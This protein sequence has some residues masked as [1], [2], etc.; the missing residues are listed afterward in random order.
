MSV[1]DIATLHQSYVRLS[2]RFKAM[3]TFHQYLQ[4]VH[5]AFLGD[6]PKVAA[7]FQALYE[8][9]KSV[10]GLLSAGEPERLRKAIAAISD[11]LTRVS[12]ELARLDQ[13][14]STS[15]L[16]RFFE[17]VKTQ[18]EKI[19]YN[20][21]KFHLYSDES[22]LE[23]HDKLDFLF[24]RLAERWD[25]VSNH[26]EMR[27]RGELVRLL[28][29]FVALRPT[30]RPLQPEEV[31][32]ARERV[33]Q[34]SEAVRRASSF[35]ALSE[36]GLLDRIRVMKRG[37][38]EAYYS[39]Q[40]LADTI[41]LSILTKNRFQSLYGEEERS[42]LESSRRVDELAADPR[43]ASPELRE[44]LERFRRH[45]EAFERGRENVNLKHEEIA[46]LRASIVDILAKFDN[47]LDDRPDRPWDPDSMSESGAFR[48]SALPPDPL[49]SQHLAR[50]FDTLELV[51]EGTATGRQLYAKQLMDL[52]LEPWE[53][54]AVRKLLMG[55]APDDPHTLELFR[56]F[57]SA[58]AL[59]NRMDEEAREL[60]RAS[61]SKEDPREI[62]AR[63]V[64][65]LERAREYDERFQWYLDEAL[66]SGL[67]E[68]LAELYRS[69]FRLV[70][71][72]SG[73]WLL[74]NKLSGSI[75]GV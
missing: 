60:L 5:K 69:K 17:R 50:I 33:G 48:I 75:P 4:G 45:R 29:G 6:L 67:G 71:S 37:L 46:A 64:R 36:S 2:D 34:L 57:V 31:D 35:D 53:I 30:R 11:E 25:P 1:E 44:E 52:R 41:E 40:V 61:D 14:I 73:L 38:G 21:I 62:L 28:E 55:E 51:E 66:Y 3:W 18:D 9:V 59:R 39:P 74:Y 23:G 26:F 24:T 68:E 63:T 47:A 32:D 49:L 70:R 72:L 7:D 65:S 15:I 42:L 43:F 58:A 54:S 19:L 10:S 8:R 27:Q 20:L 12:R 22:G 16:R 56:L 13:G